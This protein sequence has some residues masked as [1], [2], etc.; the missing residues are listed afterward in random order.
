LELEKAVFGGCRK[1]AWKG[2]TS[3]WAKVVTLLGAYSK[4]RMLVD[5]IGN[6]SQQWVN[7]FFTKNS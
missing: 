1:L 3:F 6:G 5:K 4:F 2:I 7:H